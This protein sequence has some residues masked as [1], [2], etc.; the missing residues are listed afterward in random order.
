M[1]FCMIFL[2]VVLKCFIV[3]LVVETF[4][5]GADWWPD[6]HWLTTVHIILKLTVAFRIFSFYQHGKTFLLLS[7]SRIREIPQRTDKRSIK[8][9]FVQFAVGHSKFQI[10][11]LHKRESIFSLSQFLCSSFLLLCCAQPHLDASKN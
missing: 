1:C 11:N 4:K 5:G 2:L 6:G 3:L 7:F 8:I 9:L 10:P